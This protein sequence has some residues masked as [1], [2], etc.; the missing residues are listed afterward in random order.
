MFGVVVS[1]CKEQQVVPEGNSSPISNAV[2]I[3]EGRVKFGSLDEMNTL[4]KNTE[5]KSPQQLNDM[6]GDSFKSH[7][8]IVGQIE[9]ISPETVKE[10]K[11]DLKD[12]PIS[13]PY[14]ASLLNKDREIE[15]GNDVIYK[16]GNDY[17]FYFH[18]SDTKLVEK[19]YEELKSNL[20]NVKVGELKSLYSQ[21][22]GVF[23]TVTKKNTGL[24]TD[25]KGNKS[26]RV[27]SADDSYYFNS[28]HR[29]RSQY[30]SNSYL[31]Y[32]TIGV[33]TQMEQYGTV[34]WFWKGWKSDNANKISVKV[35]DGTYVVGYDGSFPMIVLARPD[36]KE[37]T[38]T[39]EA[40]VRVDWFA[41]FKPTLNWQNGH[42]EHFVQY[43]NLS[44]TIYS[45]Y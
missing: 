28:G 42:A 38:N 19:F 9:Q 45:S 11:I 37:G 25:S 3:E 2:K 18:K 20:V 26:S 10:N 30:Y 34:Y 8:E 14:F 16:I 43:G 17:C 5:K 29:M 21:K 22:L 31:V 24:L 27:S 33:Q 23:G 4:L 13:D 40:Y 7:F 41:G 15:I 39:C 36:Y 12:T 1:S 6:I 32:S 44:N 35:L